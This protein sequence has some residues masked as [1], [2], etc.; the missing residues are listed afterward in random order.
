MV[1]TAGYILPISKPKTEKPHL[2]PC[3]K[4]AQPFYLSFDIDPH[5]SPTMPIHCPFSTIGGNITITPPVPPSDFTTSD[6]VVESIAAAAETH[7]Q[8]RER[9]KFMRDGKKDAIMGEH[10][11]GQRIMGDLVRSDA[12]LI[13]MAINPHGHWGPLAQNLLCHYTPRVDLKF[14]TSHPH[15]AAMYT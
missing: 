6:D 4:G 2:V 9:K 13:P 12:V 11:P 5:P 3:D 15:A 8:T 7:L 14:P 10:I 1:A